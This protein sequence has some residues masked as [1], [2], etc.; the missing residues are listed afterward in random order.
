[1]RFAQLQNPVPEVKEIITS[2][3]ACLEERNLTSAFELSQDAS[4]LL[5]QVDRQTVTGKLTDTDR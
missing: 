2:A 5:H 3:R 4:Q 1:V